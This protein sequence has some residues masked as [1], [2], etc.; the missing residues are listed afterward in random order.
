MEHSMSHR[1]EVWHTILS[2]S[3]IVNLVASIVK[4]ETASEIPELH[5]FQ[6]SHSLVISWGIG[7]NRDKLWDVGNLPFASYSCLSNYIIAC[8][9]IIDN[10][11]WQMLPHYLKRPF[12]S[13]EDND[14]EGA[15]TARLG[16][17]ARINL[18]FS[19]C[20]FYK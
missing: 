11:K 19:F 4:C 14:G 1:S 18:N 13:P 15:G 10:S 7:V 8:Q 17:Q 9:N 6:L 20:S 5:Y 3:V 12:P 16:D 2:E